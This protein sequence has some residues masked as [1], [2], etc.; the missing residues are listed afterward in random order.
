MHTGAMGAGIGAGAGGG[1][2]SWK[3]GTQWS[4]TCWNPAAQASHD[5]PACLHGSK[6]VLRHSLDCL[7][8]RL[9]PAFALLQVQQIADLQIQVHVCISLCMR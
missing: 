8:T 6:N 4:P 7:N 3:M 1:L 5:E 2:S 9:T